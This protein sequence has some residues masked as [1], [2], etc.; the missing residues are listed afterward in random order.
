MVE[1]GLTPFD[2]PAENIHILP[3][4]LHSRLGG[5]PGGASTVYMQQA[6]L[7]DQEGL[8]LGL[9]PFGKTIFHEMLHLKAQFSAEVNMKKGEVTRTSYREGVRVRAL[10]RDIQD[11]NDYDYFR[12]LHEAIVSSYELE[13]V[14]RLLELPIIKKEKDWLASDAAKARMDKIAQSEKIDRSEILWVSQVGTWYVK[15]SYPSQRKVVNYVIDEIDENF[16]GLFASRDAVK[17]EF[18][19]CN[20]TGNLLPIARLV[21]D[22]FGAGSF[23]VL[24]MM[25]DDK[26]SA[27]KVLKVLSTLRKNKLN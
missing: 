24:G 13:F 27:L 14:T 21:E 18:L 4:S 12:G 2:I 7:Y 25:S 16:A 17:N 3:T 9:L 26:V 20:F 10:Q 19:K 8:A 22:T 15:V 6:I 23:R 11:G 5:L 1:L